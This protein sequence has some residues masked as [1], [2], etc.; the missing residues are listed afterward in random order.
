MATRH[1]AIQ[2]GVQVH[3]QVVYT[4]S[5]NDMDVT[6][7]HSSRANCHVVGV[8]AS[9]DSIS[10][11]SR[12]GMWRF[13]RRSSRLQVMVGCLHPLQYS[14]DSN[15]HDAALSLVHRDIEIDTPVQEAPRCIMLGHNVPKT[16][17]YVVERAHGWNAKL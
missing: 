1:Q 4:G 15:R 14:P 9:P 5:A 16:P 2:Y 13:S 6:S 11:Y 7:C 10:N 8:S 3:I 17:I 12:V